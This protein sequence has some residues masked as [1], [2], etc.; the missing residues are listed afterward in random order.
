LNQSKLYT[1]FF[2]FVDPITLEINTIIMMI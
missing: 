2:K 1:T